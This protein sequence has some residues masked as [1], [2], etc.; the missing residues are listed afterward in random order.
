MSDVK[1]N[2][3]EVIKKARW[4][5]TLGLCGL[6][7]VS[8][9]LFALAQ[10]GP[11]KARVAKALAWAVSQEPDARVEVGT[12]S[13]LLPFDLH[14]DRVRVSDSA[15]DWL[16]LEDITLKWSLLSL[17]RGRAHVNELT[18][19]LADLRRLPLSNSEE[20][21]G[22]VSLPEWPESIGLLVVDELAVK[23]LILG[24]SILGKRAVY[25]VRAY[26]M[27]F[28]PGGSRVSGLQ[29]ASAYGVR[30][31]VAVTMTVQEARRMLS[32]EVL[33]E[34][35]E[36][37]PIAAAV[38]GDG[39]IGLKL[40][41]EGRLHNWHGEL[42]ATVGGIGSL[43][44]TLKVRS[45]EDLS[46][47]CEGLIDLSTG[48]FPEAVEK[49]LGRRTRFSIE[50]RIAQEAEELF[51]HRLALRAEN[52]TDLD[53]NGSVDFKENTTKGGFFL[54]SGDARN[55]AA[56]TG[57]QLGAEAS[58]KGDFSGPLLQPKVTL[59]FT[60]QDIAAPRVKAKAAEGRLVLDLM[61]PL[62]APFPGVSLAARGS[63]KGLAIP[64]S[65]VEFPAR[66]N[67]RVNAGWPAKE[68]VHIRQFNLE[69]EDILIKASGEVNLDG[70]TGSIDTT[71]EVKDLRRL[72]GLMGIELP[73]AVRVH[74]MVQVGT[75]TGAISADV[76]AKVRMIGRQYSRLE[77]LVGDEVLC[78]GR[79]VFVEDG[80]ITVSGLQVDA[81][82]AGL[83]ANASIDTES[84]A[85]DG[86]W[87]LSVPDLAAVVPLLKRDVHG[88][89]EIDGTV[90][91]PYKMPASK[92]R[93]TAQDVSMED[94]QF[95]GL[96][97]EFQTIGLPPKSG[98][99]SFSLQHA[100][101]RFRGTCDFSLH[102]SLLT[103]AGL[104][105]DA[106]KNML[107]GKAAIDL[108]RYLVRGNLQGRFQDLSSLLAFGETRIA[109]RAAFRSTFETAEAAQQV[110][111]ELDAENLSSPFGS[112]DTL[113]LR[114]T[115]HDLFDNP[116][117][118]AKLRG[119]KIRLHE[120]ALDTTEL[121]AEGSMEQVRFSGRASGRYKEGL[122]LETSGA[123]SIAPS[124]AT[125]E[126]GHLKARYSDH[127]VVLS[128]P[129]SVHMTPNGRRL[130]GLVLQVDEG[131]L[132]VSGSIEE[133]TL[134]VEAKYRDLP[135]ELLRVV[136]IADVAGKATGGISL[137][138]ERNASRGTF[139]LQVEPLTFR[140][141]RAQDLHV[142]A[143]ASKAELKDGLLRA[144]VMIKGLADRPFHADLDIPLEL[145]DPP[146]GYSL[147]PSGRLQGRLAGE[148]DLSLIPIL[149]PLVDEK[150]EGACEIDLTVLGTVKE[151]EITGTGRISN[152]AYEDARSGAVLKEIELVLAAK[153]TRLTIERL[154]ATDGNKGAVSGQG[155]IDLTPE[156]AFP[157]DIQ[158]VLDKAT[159][160]RLDTATASADGQISLTGS[161]DRASLQGRIRIEQAELRIP[162]RLS[163]DIPELKVIEI[164]AAEEVDSP[165][166]PEP[167]SGT[168][169]FLLD[170]DVISPG[171]IF[172]RG[173]GLD[174]EWQAD[175]KIRGSTSAPVVTGGLSV[176]R[177]HFNLLGKRFAVSKGSLALDGAAPPAPWLDVAAEAAAK[178]MLARLSLSG[179]MSAPTVTLSSE[180][181]L[182]SDEIL[183][184]LLF[185]RGVAT[186]TP[187]Q[188]LRLAHAVNTL[189]G[190]GGTFDFMGRTRSLL[191]VDQLE[192]KQ[193][194]EGAGGVNV[195]AGKYLR[196]GVYLELEQ[197]MGADSGKSTVQV[198]L[199]P[200]ITVET[201]VGAN[202][203]GGAGI[204]W[205]LDY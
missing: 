189:S 56:L 70:P 61:G 112:V 179:P 84:G 32:A 162:E 126:I 119:R 97:A 15:G 47:E 129:L 165:S 60:A 93:A 72:S 33:V 101:Q 107:N 149:M 19:R 121:A 188:A 170:V 42:S 175:L 10:T 132:E 159:L 161:L 204:N 185:D 177:G 202:A 55:L 158:I 18:A 131:V 194:A 152:G 39:P 27:R 7:L 141:G 68:A 99:F 4:R 146:F 115:L 41:G 103:L 186:I 122:E 106:G 143:L 34:E 73:L 114:G 92:V 85:V 110:I 174:S 81:L 3:K 59:S 13:G 22:K 195:A 2:W 104:R 95:H 20:R 164:P 86:S 63:V 38:G 88:S 30:S 156:K 163:S 145:S 98:A 192:V 52:G 35:D 155:W 147:P 31:K 167:D 37:G 130:E 127:P 150:L 184:R 24:E 28:E 11:A 67:W 74:S 80:Q 187:V 6:L 21:P 201:E 45:A 76:D 9:L 120:L 102:D 197:G 199:T 87:H 54:R 173:R 180:P 190:K 171:R 29:L 94:F 134:A 14:V 43:H 66:L 116:S 53:L 111:F 142:A 160:L 198:E 83:S 48:L 51:L 135:I 26:M 69:A 49:A 128:R 183:A 203:E 16:V 154:H 172:V 17:L 178:D 181:T 62:A 78:L 113:A 40:H 117:G 91:G 12:I 100:D 133:T 153:T 139:E 58:V 109:G 124:G 205:K 140:A 200:N 191:G 176:V 71:L 89:L 82:G 50:T 151:P 137:R 44:T 136:D 182:P 157:L 196:E 77:T 8:A 1:M 65:T 25:G 123:V 46:V 96:A 108:E 166:I 90:Q 125:I 169:D 138:T 36:G 57:S 75:G 144:N 105:I 193:P 118:S 5:L 168:F 23:E 64:D 79:V 148:I